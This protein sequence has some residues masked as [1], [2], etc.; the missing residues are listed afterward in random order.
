MYDLEEVQ[1]VSAAVSSLHVNVELDSVEVK[2]KVAEVVLTIP[3]GPEVIVVSGAVVSTV[4][5]RVA[6][7]WSRIPDELI[8]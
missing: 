3:V 2:L 7:D 1:V 5:V 6:G 4:Q 8:A